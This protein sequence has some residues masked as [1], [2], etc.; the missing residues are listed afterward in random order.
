MKLRPDYKRSIPG[1]CFPMM[2]VSPGFC[3]SNKGL[4]F[5]S[6]TGVPDVSAARKA[7]ARTDSERERF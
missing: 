1:I 6:I 4:Y 2:F 5:T 7:Q 3:S